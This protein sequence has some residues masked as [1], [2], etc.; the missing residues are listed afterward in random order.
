MNEDGKDPSNVTQAEVDA[1]MLIERTAWTCPG[2]SDAQPCLTPESRRADTGPR[3]NL[4][5]RCVTCLRIATA[6]EPTRERRLAALR[7]LAD[8]ARHSGHLVCYDP[9]E[10]RL[11]TRILMFGQNV[12]RIGEIPEL[13]LREWTAPHDLIH[14]DIFEFPAYHSII[15]GCYSYALDPPADWKRV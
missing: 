5:R 13:S 14:R 8:L 1:A 4:Q 11:V 3:R 15:D 2:V 12:A 10:G 9:F 6:A 7:A